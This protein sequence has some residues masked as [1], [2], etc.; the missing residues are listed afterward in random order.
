MAFTSL[1]NGI[2]TVQTAV[3]GVSGVK[4]APADPPEQANDF[5]FSV[6]YAGDFT[7]VQSP[8]GVLTY[9]YDFI[10]ELHIARVDLPSDIAEAYGYAESIPLAVFECLNDNGVSQ[11]ECVGRFGFLGWGGGE[12]AAPTIGFQWRFTGVKIQIVIS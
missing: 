9:L 7:I 8:T 1:D 12:D 6:T 3:A 5:P 11:S 2:E 10:V 4:Y